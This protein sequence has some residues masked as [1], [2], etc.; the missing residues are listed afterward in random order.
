MRRLAL[1]VFGLLLSASHPASAVA[2]KSCHVPGVKEAVLCGVFQVP[3]NR[4]L[5]NG[6]SLPLKVV[7]LPARTR[8]AQEPLFFL[9]GGPGEAATDAAD[10][11]ATI[12]WLR[13]THDVVFLDM[14]GTG[15]GTKL[16]CD[17]LGGSEADPQ[18][19]IEPLFHQGLAYAA[20]AKKLSKSADLTQYTT[21]IAMRDMDDL[22]KALGY[23]KIDI[24]GASY[25]TRAAIVYL[26]LYGE[27]VRAAILSGV[28]P[29]EDRS[30]LRHAA[31]AQ[32]AFDILVAQC[33]ADA[34]CH[35][36]FPDPKGDLAAILDRLRAKPVP[37]TLTD[38]RTHRP[39]TL[40]ETPA[41]FGDGLR[42][43]LYGEETG[44]RVPLILARARAGDFTPFAELALY[45][46]QG[47]KEDIALGLLL[48]VSCTEDL[49]RIRPEEIAKE[50]QGD[51]IGDYRVRGQMAACSV[52]PKGALPADYGAPFTSRVPVLLV[53][54]NLDPVTPPFWGEI[55]KKNFPDSLHVVVPGAHVSDSDC[56]EAIDRRFL[57][58]ADPKNL[59]TSC[60]TNTKL[61]PFALPRT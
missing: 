17:D 13:K 10:G 49:S 47:M 46:G 56:L 33:A 23:G 30:P 6:R 26:H 43:M 28:S 41:A 3:E 37:V 45:H 8:P 57:E 40:T 4:A 21:T 36:A 22:R 11:F 53:S 55:A 50:T 24:I 35:K 2:L 25:G 12:D 42:L 16:Q 1:A 54:G 20:C 19:Y 7:V 48:S 58:T 61:P 5:A 39:V 51:F 59:E 52:W 32:R 38:P 14:R 44:R 29:T 15:E 18:E 31:A 9:S 60:L 34:A 27:N